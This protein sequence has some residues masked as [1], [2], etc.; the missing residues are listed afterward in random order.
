M[1]SGS[2]A[3]LCPF[4]PTS[5]DWL[6][7]EWTEYCWTAVFYSIE[8]KNED[9]KPSLSSL[10]KGKK[11][12]YLRSSDFAATGN[13]NKHPRNILTENQNYTDRLKPNDLISELQAWKN[14]ASLCQATSTTISSNDDSTFQT[15]LSCAKKWH[16]T[17]HCHKYTCWQLL[18]GCSGVQNPSLDTF[19]Q[20]TRMLIL[21]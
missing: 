13:Q 14:P 18:A 11:R 5:T 19:L 9:L 7:S 21:R 15:M 10:T 20:I 17:Q 6:F 8:R 3:H 1:W 16:S 2:W 4:N 12:K